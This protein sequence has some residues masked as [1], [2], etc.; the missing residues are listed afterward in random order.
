MI[1]PLLPTGTILNDAF[2]EGRVA[3]VTGASRGLGKPIAESLAAAGASVALVAR[4]RDLLESV[5]SG[6]RSNSGVAEVIVTDVCDQAA[7]AELSLRVNEKLGPC[8]ILVNNAGINI[9]KAIDEFTLDEWNRLITTN[10]TGP[11]LMCN[12]FVPAMKEKGFGRVINIA[13]IASHISKPRLAGYSATKAGLLGMTKGLAL[14][15]APYSVTVN[16]I[17]PGPFATDMNREILDDPAL[18]KQFVE[19]IPLK[20]WGKP[21]EIGPLAA[22]LCREEAGFITGTDIV[23][24]GGRIAE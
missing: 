13:S 4:N 21:E 5:A 3:V 9:R 1:L 2:L 17:S 11:F 14:E 20:R 6:I 16:A 12:A 23:I 8:D 19:G 15:L 18:N 10:L 7:V 24:D 22:Y